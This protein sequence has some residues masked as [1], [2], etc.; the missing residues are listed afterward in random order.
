MSILVIGRML[1]SRLTFLLL[2]RGFDVAKK[3]RLVPEQVMQAH[4]L[5]HFCDRLD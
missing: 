3:F 1:T 5:R 2:A 4:A